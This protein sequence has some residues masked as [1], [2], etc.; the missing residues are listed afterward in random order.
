MKQNRYR[1]LSRVSL[2]AVAE[3]F[4]IRHERGIN[5]GRGARA[6]AVRQRLFPGAIVAAADCE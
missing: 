2:P 4:D 1:F 6:T 5:H 3:R